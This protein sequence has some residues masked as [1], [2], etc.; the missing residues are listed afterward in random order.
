MDC[1]VAYEPQKPAV[2]HDHPEGGLLPPDLLARI[3]ATDAELG[4]LTPA[5]Y[6]LERGE[7]LSEAAAQATLTQLNAVESGL[8]ETREQWV[9]PLFR[10]LGY[11]RLS[12]RTT[13]ETIDDRSYPIS[14]RCSVR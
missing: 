2:H 12:Y 7:R 6:G 14:H 3:A 1:G 13:A 9:L 8:S 4:G 10:A 11:G 5:D